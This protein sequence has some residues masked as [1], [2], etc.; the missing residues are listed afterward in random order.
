[1]ESVSRAPTIRHVH[2]ADLQG[3]LHP[4][5]TPQQIFIRPSSIVNGAKSRAADDVEDQGDALGWE[6]FL[7]GEE[8]GVRSSG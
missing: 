1:M 7:G 8:H 4:E 5:K 3:R 2:H 6:V